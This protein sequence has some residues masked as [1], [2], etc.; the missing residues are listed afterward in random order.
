MFSHT[1]S[2][3]T[4]ETMM[5]AFGLHPPALQTLAEIV[6]AIDLHDSHDIQ[7]EISG[8]AAI[9]EGWLFLDV[10]DAERKTWG[11]ALFEGL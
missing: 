6:R 7:P 8:V 5:A 9:S 1:G 10:P 3:C 11:Q 4:F 2:Q